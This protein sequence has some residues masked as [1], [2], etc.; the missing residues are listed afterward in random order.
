M[1]MNDGGGRLSPE[2]YARIKQQIDKQFSDAQYA[3]RPLLLEG[4][5]EWKEMTLSPRDMDFLNIKHSAAWDIALAF[6]VLLEFLGI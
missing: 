1:N 3:G 2:Q 6:G 4:V 5:L